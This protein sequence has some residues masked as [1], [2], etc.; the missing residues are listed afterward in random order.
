MFS[1]ISFI[2]TVAC[3]IFTIHCCLSIRRDSKAVDKAVA[4]HQQWLKDQ[5]IKK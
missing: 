4:E 1:I 2:I 5:G 3:F